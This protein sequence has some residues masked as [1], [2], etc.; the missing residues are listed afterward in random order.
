MRS[1]WQL[2]IGTTAL[3]LVGALIWADRNVVNSSQTT[4]VPLAMSANV[5]E[6][7]PVL[8]IP[9]PEAN[10]FVAAPPVMPSTPSMALPPSLPRSL[11]PEPVPP[12]LTLPVLVTPPEPAN[13]VNPLI[14]MIAVPPAPPEPTPPTM[15]PSRDCEDTPVVAPPA[16]GEP[17]VVT[18]VVSVSA[19]AAPVVETPAPPTGTPFP[20]RFSMEM[21][22]TMTQ[23]EL[24]RGDESLIR[25][26]CEA[27]EFSSP[28]GGL[29]ARG[30]VVVTGPC[31]EARCERLTLAWHSGEVAL[32][33]GVHLSVRHEGLV[34]MMRAEALTF[35]LGGAN[36]PVEFTTRDVQIPVQPKP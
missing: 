21:A 2:V 24:R 5:C 25:V 22:G 30:K 17:P 4:P 1:S 19:P 36:Q 32:D 11:N 28:G 3:A 12:S 31:H 33:G 26:Q 15:P 34:Q 14:E 20:W 23:I 6:P 27:V 13:A 35:R 29:V 9:E 8:T 7:A 16:T 10:T 18:P